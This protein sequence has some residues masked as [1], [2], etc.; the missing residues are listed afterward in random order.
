LL[1]RRTKK[2]KVKAKAEEGKQ[3]I[4]KK[5]NKEKKNQKRT[6]ERKNFL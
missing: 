3:L 2:A 4:M 1:K 6:K 5:T